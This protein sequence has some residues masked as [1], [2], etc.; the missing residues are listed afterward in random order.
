MGKYKV[1][2]V[3]AELDEVRPFQDLIRR[4]GEEFS[5]SN[6]ER[7]PIDLEELARF[8]DTNTWHRRCC[9]IKATTATA[10]GYT[11]IS[12]TK[13]ENK[14]D[15]ARLVHFLQN[16]YEEGSLVDLLEKILKDYEALGNAYIE[17]L[18]NLKGEIVGLNHVPALWVRILK[19]EIGY[20]YTE[21][22]TPIFF[23]KFED[24]ERR[25]KY[26]FEFTD[27]IEEEATEII[28]FKNYSISSPFYG[29][30]DFITSLTAM[31]GLEE[32]AKYNL[33]FFSNATVARHILMFT[34]K[35][36]LPPSVIESINNY[37]KGLKR[38]PHASLVIDAPPETE[39][40]DIRLTEDIEDA[41][42]LNYRNASKEEIITAHGVPPRMVSIMEAG[43]L[44]SGSEAEEQRKQ[45]YELV[46]SPL[47]RKLEYLIN[48]KI[49]RRGL[50]IHSY[51]I[52]LNNP[53]LT[54]ETEEAKIHRTYYLMGVLSPNEIRK[55]KGLDPIENEYADYHWVN[56]NF[57]IEL[58]NKNQDLSV[59]KVDK[60]LNILQ[61]D[62][63]REKP[64]EERGDGSIKDLQVLENED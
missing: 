63:W 48:E 52:K 39:L 3:N 9:I 4:K 23:K 61:E 21:G 14:E 25:S 19:N 59:F 43:R 15:R 22:D 40:K 7:P 32:V 57:P 42:F 35:E 29:I 8:Y 62:E 53:S 17:V 38:V 37:L 47:Q 50:G 24:T 45:F 46:I 34:G 6:I 11:I 1:R 18:R 56:G 55:M 28:A 33:D 51:Q 16:C 64:P 31:K 30:P 26:T 49:I 2:V 58:L 20:V 27:D 5:V 41:S 60:K 54:A 10:Y 44:G 12:V 36:E 13:D